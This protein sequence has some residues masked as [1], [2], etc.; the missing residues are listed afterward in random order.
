MARRKCRFAD[1]EHKDVDLRKYAKIIEDTINKTVPGKNPKVYENYFSTDVLDQREAAAI[2]RALY[3]CY[4]VV[5]VV[6]NQ[7]E[8]LR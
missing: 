6:E 1:S 2:G 4:N 8:F 5:D 3:C 7:C